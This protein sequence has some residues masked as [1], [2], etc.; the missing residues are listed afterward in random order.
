MTAKPFSLS[1]PTMVVRLRREPKPLADWGY[2][3]HMVQRYPNGRTWIVEN[4]RIKHSGSTVCGLR[5]RT[6]SYKLEAARLRAASSKDLCN[7]CF[8]GLI[9]SPSTDPVQL[10]LG[11]E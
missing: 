3:W 4:G 5:L 10:T 1:L 7:K 6:S 2:R 9:L 11:L 8:G